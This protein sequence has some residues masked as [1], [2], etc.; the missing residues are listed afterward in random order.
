MCYKSG[1]IYLL[2]TVAVFQNRFRCAKIRPFSFP[3]YLFMDS[4]S[5]R[6]LID[7]NRAG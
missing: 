5:C 7:V 1:Q 3:E 6:L 2:L 4:P